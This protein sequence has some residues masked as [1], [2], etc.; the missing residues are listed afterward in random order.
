MYYKAKREDIDFLVKSQI[1]YVLKNNLSYGHKRIAIALSLNHK[2][3]LRVMH[4]YGI[5]PYRRRRKVFIKKQDLKRSET[6]FNNLIA[7]LSIIYPH[8]V[9]AEDF[10]YIKY[11]GKFI[12]LA[13]VIDIYSRKIVGF[14]ISNR[15]DTKLIMESLENALQNHPKPT[16]IHS[17][18]GSEYDSQIYYDFCRI[19]GIQISMSKKSSPWENGYQESFYNNFKIELADVNRF[20]TIEDLMIEIGNQIYYYNNHRIHSKLKTNPNQFLEFHYKNMGT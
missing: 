12:Y 2:R 20:D 17:D 9:W 8:Q 3:I 16:I 18:Q 19:I 14:S 11:M 4:K 7:N 1:E 5:K 15:H 6:P 13:T 10:T